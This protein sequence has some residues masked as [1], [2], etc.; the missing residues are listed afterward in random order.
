MFDKLAL[1]FTPEI[2][3]YLSCSPTC[4][5]KQNPLPDTRDLIPLKLKCCSSGLRHSLLT[6]VGVQRPGAPV[7]GARR[8]RGPLLQVLQCPARLQ[9][10]VVQEWQGVLQV[11]YILF[12]FFTFVHYC[13]LL[14][15][16]TT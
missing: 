1:A 8:A 13:T 5:R 15:M 4:L 3:H 12:F 10:Q 2:S 7:R 14:K 6:G 11:I 16:N 9:R